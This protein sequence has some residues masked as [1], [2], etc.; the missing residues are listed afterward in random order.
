MYVRDANEVRGEEG[1]LVGSLRDSEL[2]VAACHAHEEILNI[3]AVLGTGL[4]EGDVLLVGEGL[5]FI[6]LD[7][8]LI[9]E[10]R[11]VSDDYLVNFFVTVLLDLTEPVLD[12]V[13]GLLVGDIID[14]DVTVSSAVVRLGDGTEALLASSIPLRLSQSKAR[15]VV[16]RG[17][18][19]AKGKVGERSDAHERGTDVQF[20]S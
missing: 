1:T 19:R 14:K 9:F 13:E 7:H 10:I 17:L 18:D 11:L 5:T 6:I 4:E 12:V 2:E 20:E 8:A 15:N 3:E 16:S